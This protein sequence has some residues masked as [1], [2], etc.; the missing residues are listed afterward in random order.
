MKL[1]D[2]DNSNANVIDGGDVLLA[3]SANEIVEGSIEGQNSWVL[4]STASMHICKDKSSFD[5]LCSHGEYGYITV[6]NNDKLKVEGVRSVC[7]KLKNGRVK[8]FHNVK[9]VPGASINLI[10]LAELTSHG[11][12]YV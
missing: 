4:D 9:H 3:K 1:Q 7:L 11:Y 8:T 6:G 5:T 12:K 10:S 2:E